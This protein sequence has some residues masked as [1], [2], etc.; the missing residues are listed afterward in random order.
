MT[1]SSFFSDELLQQM[2]QQADPIADATIAALLTSSS[3]AGK[4]SWWDKI[5]TNEAPLP[6]DLPMPVQA[7]FAE[8]ES[9]PPWTDYRRIR[10]GQQFFLTHAQS[11]LS[12]LGC[13]SLP[14][15]YA[16][17][18]GVQVLWLSQRIRQNTR[19]RLA[20]T[21]HFILDVL[22]PG[23]FE[24]HGKGIRSIQKVR[25]IHALSRHY[26][27]LSPKWNSDWGVPVNQEDMIGTNLAFSYILLR[28]LEKSGTIWQKEEAEDFLHTWNVIG[29]MLGIDIQL[30][31]QTLQEAYWLDKKIKNRHFRR[32]EA[33][34]ELC[35]SLI[36][37]LYET[38]QTQVT[39][40]FLTSYVRYLLGDEVADVLD[41]PPASES[42]LLI[43]LVKSVS[44][45]ANL[46]NSFSKPDARRITSELQTQLQQDAAPG[47]WLPIAFG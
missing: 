9:M 18:D 34:V 30:L 20:E 27:Q 42:K 37:C 10:R 29:F 35:R 31:P 4:F 41:L 45:L 26:A 24:A 12:V 38:N 6:D 8:T 23:A 36:N 5:S 40:P 43:P 22:S 39:K 44:L 14:Y 11:I 1:I 16:A 3:Q 47:F 32:S 2:R 7:Y 19:Q 46:L 33:G 21:G 17:A 15:C 28:G 13:L 25:L